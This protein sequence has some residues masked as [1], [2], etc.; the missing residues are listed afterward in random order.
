MPSWRDDRESR[1]SGSE[2]C[3]LLLMW[4]EGLTKIPLAGTTL[5]EGLHVREPPPRCQLQQRQK[6]GQ[7]QSRKCFRYKHGQRSWI[8]MWKFLA[9]MNP[10][11]PSWRISIHIAGNP[12]S[13]MG[14]ILLGRSWRSS[15]KKA[16]LYILPQLSWGQQFCWKRRNWN[17]CEWVR[18]IIRGVCAYWSSSQQDCSLS[19]HDF[20]PDF[21]IH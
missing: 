15:R 19:P 5:I 10:Q 2:F 13:S 8:I 21:S 12:N 3:C 1:W 20:C 18:W 4:F 17:P 11:Q 6:R 7:R 9:N 16:G 14:C